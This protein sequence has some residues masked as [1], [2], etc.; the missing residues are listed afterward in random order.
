MQSLSLVPFSLVFDGLPMMV[1]FSMGSGVGLWVALQVLAWISIFS[2]HYG[3]RRCSGLGLQ[4]DG[5]EMGYRVNCEI[6]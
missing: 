1:G 5:V 3:L 6:V 2:F 4:Y